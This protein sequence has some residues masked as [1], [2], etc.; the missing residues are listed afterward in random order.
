M[1]A[2]EIAEKL[3]PAQ[4]RDIVLLANGQTPKA[5]HNRW[6]IGFL[7][8]YDLVLETTPRRPSGRRIGQPTYTITALGREVAK[9][10]EKES[11]R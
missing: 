3:T 7:A 1:T 2:E 10:L 6:P 5:Y 11:G 9:A 8:N 4:K